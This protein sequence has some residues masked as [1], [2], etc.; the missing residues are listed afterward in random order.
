M[1]DA[2]ANLAR[3]IAE[4][5]EDYASIS[6][7]IG[8]NAAYI[9]QYIRRGTPRF[10]SERDRQLIAR[11][12]GVDEQQ[13]GAPE[14]MAGGHGDALHIVP[15][16][17]IGASAGGGNI[18]Y[19]EHIF[20]AQGFE[21]NW[22]RDRGWHHGKL[23]MIRVEG[24]SMEPTLV[25]GDELLVEATGEIRRE[26]IYVLRMDDALMVKRLA[27]A[28]GERLSIRSDN[29]AYPSWEDVEASKVEIIGRVVWVG[30][31]L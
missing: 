1:V 30:R 14:A 8:R 19:D 27:R 10:L 13:L 3:L 15:R 20:G 11:H 26:G 29:A 25:H 16:Y 6:R 23:G 21:T 2:R 17:D 4:N 5:G 28:P 9:Q 31:A 12:F 7:L 22:L 24:D 18:T